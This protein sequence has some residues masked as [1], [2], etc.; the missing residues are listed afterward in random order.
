V[1]IFCLFVIWWILV[2]VFPQARY[3]IASPQELFRAFLSSLQSVGFWGDVSLTLSRAVGAFL[4]GAIIGIPLGI[5]LGRI[6]WLVCALELPIDFARSIPM[7][8]LFPAFVLWLGIGSRP[9]VA[10]AAF[11]CTMTFIINVMY[12][13]HNRRLQRESYVRSLGAG[14]WKILTK[15]IL[16]DISSPMLSATRLSLSTSLVLI[17]V[18]EML[19]GG[20]GGLGQRIQDFRFAY[21]IPQMW[22]AILM[23]GLIGLGLN[24]LL[25]LLERKIIHWQGQ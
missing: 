7:S 25:A 17:V 16:W 15:V 10:A 22:V 5:L 8:A 12:G 13:V 2:K 4:L 21:R 24:Q 9:Q 18:T 23:I 14:E 11:G 1:G 6:E 3:I 19:S 20:T